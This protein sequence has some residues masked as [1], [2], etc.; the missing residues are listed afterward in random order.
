MVRIV[1]I[2]FALAILVL[3][4]TTSVAWA[5][6]TYTFVDYA[7]ID[8]GGQYSV[9]GTIDN[10][11]LLGSNDVSNLN[12]DTLTLTTPTT[13][14]SAF[15]SPALLPIPGNLTGADGADS[16][17][18]A[19][20]THLAL[21]PNQSLEISWLTGASVGGPSITI[22][23]ENY[24]SSQEIVATMFTPRAVVGHQYY[25]LFD[26]IVA[27]PEIDA[28]GNWIIANAVPEPATSST[29]PEPATLII[30]SLLGSL[31][32]GLGRWRRGKAT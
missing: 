11:G 4:S 20:P 28:H 5:S 31:A 9:S 30:W 19:S 18:W 2:A 25:T 8:T 1:R 21:A 16:N 24:G 23:W 3:V 7:S 22:D 6:I 17:I 29:V 12:L 26:N 32:V 15:A 14:Y 10:G 27:A 13:T